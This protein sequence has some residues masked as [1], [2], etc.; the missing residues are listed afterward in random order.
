MAIYY[1]EIEF[2]AY[3]DAVRGR[4][5]LQAQHDLK[6]IVAGELARGADRRRILVVLDRLADD[7][8]A[9]GDTDRENAVLDVM[10]AMTGR[11][12]PT[13]AI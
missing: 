10:D 6:E 8:G 3:A 2:E 1:P 4:S 9:H 12:H 13:S 5:L 11:V 7:L